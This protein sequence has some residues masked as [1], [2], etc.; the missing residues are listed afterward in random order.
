[1]AGKEGGGENCLALWPLPHTLSELGQWDTPRAEILSWEG[2]RRGET[3]IAILCK[4]RPSSAR[5]TASSPARA[6]AAD[7]YLKL[8]GREEGWGRAGGSQRRGVGEER[9]AGKQSKPESTE[10]I[11]GRGRPAGSRPSGCSLPGRPP[12]GEHSGRGKGRPAGKGEPSGLRAPAPGA[13]DSSVRG[14]T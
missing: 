4:H 8:K 14:V 10:Q 6:G 3:L 12:A 2:G 7:K 9:S 5:Q 11:W 13:W 1:M